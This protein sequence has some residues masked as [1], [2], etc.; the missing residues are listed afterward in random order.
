M[1]PPMPRSASCSLIFPNSLQHPSPNHLLAWTHEPQALSQPWTTAII[2]PRR[3]TMAARSPSRSVQTGV[4]R[5][6]FVHGF[7]ANSTVLRVDTGQLV[8]HAVF[9]SRLD[10]TLLTNNAPTCWFTYGR[11]ARR[12]P[13]SPSIPRRTAGCDRSTRRPFGR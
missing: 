2:I 10:A 12:S 8:R 11:T 1:R 7:I 6:G 13:P 9:W 5:L 3:V 4:R